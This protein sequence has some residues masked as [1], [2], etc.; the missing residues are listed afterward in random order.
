MKRGIIRTA[1]RVLRQRPGLLCF[2]ALGLATDA[3]VLA[4]SWPLLLQGVWHRF[5][6]DEAPTGVQSAAIALVLWTASALSSV[7]TAALVHSVH[8]LLGGERLP[9]SASLRAAGRRLPTLLSWSLFSLVAGSMLRTGESLAGLSALFELLGLSW[10]L[11][12]FFAL[13]VIVVEGT[14]LVASLRRSL[15]LGRHALGRWVAGGL[16]LLVTTTLVVIGAIV[17]LIL[18][19]EANSLAVLFAAVATVMAVGLLVTVVNSAASGIYRT[20][21]YRETVA[22]A[23]RGSDGLLLRGTGPA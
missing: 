1:A 23:G 4:A 7:F 22:T 21:L 11:L 2:P 12:T 3:A 17:V 10:S 9:V 13:P 15:T 19:V 18:A 5:V 20:S 8:A 6:H 16:K 14:G